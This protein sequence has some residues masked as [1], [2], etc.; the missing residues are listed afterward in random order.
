MDDTPPPPFALTDA[1]LFTGDVFVEG[2][3]LLVDEGHVLDIIPNAK[4]PPHVSVH[5]CA[6]RIL[7]PGFIDCQVNGGGNVLLNNDPTPDSILA[8][9]AAHRKTGTTALL[10]TIITDAPDVTRKAIEA[11]RQARAENP[12][13]LGIHIEGPHISEE[14]KGIHDGNH[15][16]PL[17]LS[18]EILYKP[19]E[20]E[21]VLVTLAPEQATPEQIERL[22]RGGAIISLGHTAA[23][24]EEIRAALA[25]GA[26]G[27]THLYNGMGP[28]RSREPGPA[29]VAL[30]DPESWCSLI[31]DGHHVAPELIR[32][33]LKAKPENKLFFVSDAMAPAGA[34][35]PE[36]FFLNGE[37][38]SPDGD[39]CRNAESRIAGAM[40]TLGEMVSHAIRELKMDPRRA[41]RM[42]SAFPAA[43]LG[44]EKK[45]GFLLPSYRADIVAL[46]HFFKAQEV[47]QRGRRTD[48]ADPK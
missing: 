15:I 7:A 48:I 3:A 26:T 31:A 35:K 8:I 9:A 41:L 45:I 12:A 4:I 2:H 30:D 32:L 16:R 47:W 23:R 10:P 33:A 46:D 29:G 25:A 44:L 27:F 21:I 28:I 39:V 18:D 43:F 37:K 20:D 40:M 42:A 11:V 17:G 19:E 1:I 14:N 24:P 38:I 6:G 34:E 22:W 13:I 5:S 36:P